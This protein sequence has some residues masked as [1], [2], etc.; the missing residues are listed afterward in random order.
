MGVSCGLVGLPNVGKTTVFNAMT[1]AAAE[2]T[3]YATSSADPNV[4][5]IDVPD[6]RLSVIEG[7]IPTKK[8]VHARVKVVDVPGLAEGASRGVGIGNAFLGNIKEADALMHVVQCFDSP[9]V[10]RERPVDPS[11]DMDVLEL[12][13]AAADF[14]TVSRNI[15]RVSKKARA[16]DKEATQEKEIFERARA[17]LEDGVQLRTVDW[18]D[19]ERAILRPLFLLTLKPVLFRRERRR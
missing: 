18:K 5:E 11:A 8:L 19:T 1:G 12:E 2:R 7:F 17:L 13:L 16:G 3:T 15:D 4:A 6:D 9:Q 10:S 14:E